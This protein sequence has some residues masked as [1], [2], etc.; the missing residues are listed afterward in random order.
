[1]SITMSRIFSTSV[2]GTL[3]AIGLMLSTSPLRAEGKLDTIEAFSSGKAE[4]IVATYYDPATGDASKKVGLI[5]IGA[6]R[7]NS[8]AFDR[9]EWTRLI[10]L[11]DKAIA[12]QAATWTSAGT[13]TETGT[14]DV[15]KLSVSAGPG[16]RF[17]ISSPK[18]LTVTYVLQKADAPRFQ[19]ALRQVRDFLAK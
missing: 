12:V 14:T 3:L 17:V 10:A 11:C 2:L 16:V 8:F 19:K 1:M 5:A 6:P 7:R 4:M 18:G 15:S 13:M 9:D